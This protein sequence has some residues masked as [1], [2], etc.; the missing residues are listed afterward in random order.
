MMNNDQERL[1][2]S[3]VFTADDYLHICCIPLITQHLSEW[4]TI[5]LINQ[6]KNH[7]LAQ[8]YG[9]QHLCKIKNFK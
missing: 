7:K 3:F 5:P 1:S 9:E 6:V 4:I 2:C 8:T